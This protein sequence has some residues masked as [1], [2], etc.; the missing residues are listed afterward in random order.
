MPLL[1]SNTYCIETLPQFKNRL[2]VQNQEIIRA[3]PAG[4]QQ[5]LLKMFNEIREGQDLETVDF[6]GDLHHEE[7]QDIVDHDLSLDQIINYVLNNRESYYTYDSD[8]S[9]FRITEINDEQVEAHEQQYEVHELNGDNRRN[10]IGSVTAK[11]LTE[12]RKA[13]VDEYGAPVEVT[14]P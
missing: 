7:I 9:I 8:I 11:T 5:D 14:E 3:L 10:R 2:D 12:A 13:A 1:K 4:R 6:I